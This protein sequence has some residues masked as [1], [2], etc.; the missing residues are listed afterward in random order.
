VAC[1]VSS[2]QNDSGLHLKKP[3]SSTLLAMLSAAE[4]RGEFCNSHDRS[5]QFM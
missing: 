2:S 3:I 1:D 5:T 4:P